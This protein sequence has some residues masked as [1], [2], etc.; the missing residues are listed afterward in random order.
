M[1]KLFIIGWSILFAAIML[2]GIIAKW[3]IVGWYDFINL[4]VQ[5]KAE[6]FRYL[7]VIDYAWLFFAYPMLLGLSYKAG[8]LL[9]DRVAEIF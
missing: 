7:R 9:Y 1:L 8:E 2:N 5:K 6:A 4:L 3:G